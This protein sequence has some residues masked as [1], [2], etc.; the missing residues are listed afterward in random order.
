MSPGIEGKPENIVGFGS[1]ELVIVPVTDYE[2][3]KHI[4]NV[5]AANPSLATQKDNTRDWGSPDESNEF[6]LGKYTL[7]DKSKYGKTTLNSNN[8]ILEEI[9]KDY[10]ML[11][12]KKQ[13]II[14]KLRQQ[15]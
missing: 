5:F 8:A 4:V 3:G 2:I 11:Y 10:Q 12:D 14:N 1:N 15:E 6:Y 7:F 9:I 13:E